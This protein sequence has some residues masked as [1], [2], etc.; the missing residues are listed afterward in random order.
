M[1]RPSHYIEKSLHFTCHNT[2]SFFVICTPV[3][4]LQDLE[5]SR[6]CGSY[7]HSLD[8]FR[9]AQTDVHRLQL[10]RPHIPLIRWYQRHEPHGEKTQSHE[11]CLFI[12]HLFSMHSPRIL[13]ICLTIS[14]LISLLLS[15]RSSF[16][17]SL[18]PSYLFFPPLLP[19]LLPHLSPSPPSLLNRLLLSSHF[20]LSTELT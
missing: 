2:T 12:D 13:S 20:S 18:L 17:S 7:S 3:M 11:Y 4:P 10:W 19:P 5:R 8:H 9:R 16:L 6:Q 14:L 15:L 1:H